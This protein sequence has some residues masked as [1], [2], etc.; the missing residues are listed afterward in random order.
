[1]WYPPIYQVDITSWYQ[2]IG[3]GFF[4]CVNSTN[5]R[6][7]LDYIDAVEFCETLGSKVEWI[8]LSDAK[9]YAREILAG[10]ITS[11]L[12]EPPFIFWTGVVRKNDSYFRNGT[13]DVKLSAFPET[14]FLSTIVSGKGCILGARLEVSLAPIPT[15]DLDGKLS[16]RHTNYV[17]TCFCKVFDWKIFFQTRKDLKTFEF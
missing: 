15:K 8:S 17:A 4:K 11:H 14:E 2:H 3:L 9:N 13:E 10:N 16:N 6:Q 7:P 1:M 12:W 5:V